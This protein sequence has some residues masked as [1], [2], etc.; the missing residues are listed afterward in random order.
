MGCIVLKLNAGDDIMIF[1][2]KTVTVV[3]QAS[4]AIALLALIAVNALTPFRDKPRS[5][6]SAADEEYVSS[7]SV[8]RETSSEAPVEPEK[9]IET[10]RA[11]ISVTGDVIIHNAL[12]E[13]A[14]VSDKKY[15]FDFIYKSFRNYVSASDYAVTN[16]ETTLGGSDYTGYPVF[17][18]PDSLID[19]ITGAG[20]D[21][22]LTANNHANDTGYK[23][24][25]RT[26]KVL[27]RKKVDF[28]GTV[29]N[30]KDKR[31]L[32]KEVNGIKIGMI[33]YTY[34]GRARAGGMKY[35]NGMMNKKSAA[36]INTFNVR[37]LDEFYKQLGG[38]MTAMRDE[39]AEAIMVYLHWGEEYKLDPNKS[40]KEIAQ[41]LCDMGV[42][43]IVGGHPHVIQPMQLM[44]SRSDS[45]H[46]TVCIYS[47]GNSVSNQR[48]KYS[49][50]N[51]GHTEDGVFVSFTFSKYS[52]GSVIVS[53][54][55][56]LPTW[57]NV[58]YSGG[59]RIFEIIPLDKSVS[60][61]K[62]TFSLDKSGFKSADASFKRTMNIIGDGLKASQEYCREH[63]VQKVQ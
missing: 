16:L 32:V 47:T 5:F 9:I 22:L 48:S 54:V 19:S 62:Q 57:V 14:K 17:N 33:C 36:I 55:E 35:L 24:M 60:D 30:A 3:L 50:I 40:Q 51:T 27:K 53:D 6:V 45:Q 63:A 59:R 37:N 23:G 34:E 28:I 43:V 21:M 1:K 56:A 10:A 25:T 38:R 41:K 58:Y 15:N 39:G 8:A 20:F 42:D 52:D 29:E 4:A 49:E 11:R 18:T 31:Y 61:W 44:T 13:T 26:A 46:K 2:S 7:C 12:L